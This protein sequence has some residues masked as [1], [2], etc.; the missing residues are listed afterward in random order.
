MNKPKEKASTK[1]SELEQ[2]KH[3]NLCLK[4]ELEYLKKLQAVVESK[5]KQQQ[6][7]K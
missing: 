6:K 3:E 4:A 5:K 2:L 7:K 1:K